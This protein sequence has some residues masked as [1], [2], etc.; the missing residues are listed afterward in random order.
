[1][2]ARLS[3]E[4][5]GNDRWQDLSE[6]GLTAW[7]QHDEGVLNSLHR[8]PRG[9]LPPSQQLTYDE[10]ER[11]V[12][13]RVEEFHRRLYLANFLSV[14]L[15]FWPPV[16]QALTFAEQ[17]SFN[18]TQD[19]EDW[20]RR[21]DALPAFLDQNQKLMRQGM[22][23]HWTEIKRDAQRTIELVET[24]RQ[25][26]VEETLF[27][28]PFKQFPDTVPNSYRAKLIDRAKQTIASRVQPALERF[29]DFLK[30][31]Y[32]PACQDSPGLS[33]WQGGPELYGYLAKQETGTELSVEEIRALGNREL[34]RIRKEMEG[35][36]PRIGH[37]TTLPE[38]FD[39]IKTA[40]ELH[41]Q[42]DD[43]LLTAYRATAKR[44]DPTIVKVF[45]ELPRTP[46]GVQGIK[47][48]RGLGGVYR[49]PKNADQ[50]G[51]VVVDIAK[52][53]I[54]PKNE[55]LAIL[56][57]EAVPGHHLQYA[58]DL[59]RRSESASTERI[60]SGRSADDILQLSSLSSR[61]TGFVEGWGLYAESLGDE[62]G[63]YT[64]PLEKFGELNLKLS[65]AARVMVDTG[66][67][68]LGWDLD[69]ATKYFADTTG[70]PISVAK[71]E[72]A[73]S[74]DI[75]GHL[76]GYTIG[77]LQFQALRSRAARELGSKFD[78]REFHNFMLQA[79]P[80]PFDILE[81]DLEGWIS[82]R[83]S[84]SLRNAG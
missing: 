21:L 73:V 59:E 11:E 1:M 43:E 65:R 67:H 30:N 39:W 35:L 42:T 45:K 5:I 51:M 27:F 22:Q 48:G 63:L 33:H 23:V 70:K 41:C 15:R 7:R 9:K 84:E 81:R 26:T 29:G 36:L 74:I 64:D 37:G 19:Y 79:G 40:P 58:L 76:L 72:V 49:R 61:D 56:L 77:Q 8:I 44:I 13:A 28:E 18:S 4:N 60:G 16:P 57:H 50:A 82:K 14:A 6:E 46:Y 25:A 12:A 32:L 62:L 17:L 78:V 66:I 31:E 69:K 24:Q 71:D 20:V 52:P 38:V 80:I 2:L 34:E 53:E 68:S 47:A 75:P 10:F 83:K 54:R 3:G 55:I